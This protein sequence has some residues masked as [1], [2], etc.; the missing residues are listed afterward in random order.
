MYILGTYT[1]NYGIAIL[2]AQ[3][4]QQPTPKIRIDFIILLIIA[5]RHYRRKH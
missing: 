3:Q 4:N 1:L 5:Y 2:D